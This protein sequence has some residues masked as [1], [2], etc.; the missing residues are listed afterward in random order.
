MNSSCTIEN[1]P[2]RLVN[3]CNLAFSRQTGLRLLNGRCIVHVPNMSQL[4]VAYAE[5]HRSQCGCQSHNHSIFHLA[6][7]HFFVQTRVVDVT[8]ADKAGIPR[9]RHGHGHGHGHRHPRRHPREDR[10]ENVGVSFIL[11]QELP[12]EIARVGCVGKDPRED[13][14]VGVGVVEFQLK[15]VFARMCANS[16]NGP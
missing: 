3:F 11:S 6:F 10:S 8:M 1:A 16:V 4:D 12:Q 14:R 13:V 7:L 2:T 15:R 5:A 9:R